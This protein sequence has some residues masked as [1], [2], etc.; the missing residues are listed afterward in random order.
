LTP[1]LIASSDRAGEH[2]VMVGVLALLAVVVGLIYGLVRLVGKRRVART[3]P[4]DEASG[5]A[6]P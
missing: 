1:A 5:G 4:D 2:F 6:G 3:Q